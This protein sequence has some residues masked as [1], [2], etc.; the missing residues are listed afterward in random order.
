MAPVPDETSV[1]YSEAAIPSTAKNLDV[2]FNQ[3]SRPTLNK[4]VVYRQDWVLKNVFIM[5]ILHLL[6]LNGLWF[7]L[8]LKAMWQTIVFCK[9]YLSF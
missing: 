4:D 3:A 6:A 8:T 5:I 1:L 9:Y 2:K 7:I